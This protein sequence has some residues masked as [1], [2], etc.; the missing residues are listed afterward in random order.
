MEATHTTS[1]ENVQGKDTKFQSQPISGINT[2]DSDDVFFID[3]TPEQNPNKPPD[4]WEMFCKTILDQS[5]DYPEPIPLVYLVN[6][7]DKR[8]IMT[9]GS[10]SLW[11]G[12]AKSKKTTVLGMAI[13]SYISPIQSID[14][15]RFERASDTGKVLF[16]DNEQGASY[17]ARTMRRI[18][19]IAGVENSALLNYCDF[20][21]GSPNDRFHMIV[22]ALQRDPEINIVVIDGLV[23]LMV[24]FMDAQEGHELIRQ[25]LSLCSF[26]DIHIAGILHQNK[27]DKNAR[28]HVGTISGQKCEIEISCEVNPNDKAMTIVE[29]RA[30]R[31]IPFETVAIRWDKGSLPVFVQDFQPE[32]SGSVKGKVKFGVDSLTDVEHIHAVNEV[33]KSD[34]AVNNSALKDF[35][36]VVLKK[37]GKISETLAREFVAHWTMKKYVTITKGHRNANIYSKNDAVCCVE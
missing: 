16:I 25:I 9:K 36:K 6:G 32:M 2:S 30:A 15:V 10:F 19:S 27:G 33:F 4:Y 20:R 5:K 37:W 29:C 28:A 11:Q 34:N 7:E 12:K 23:D 26:Y 17:A 13:A 3:A 8:P 18:L 24:D 31:G 21:Q 22:A 1:P 14:T 35:I